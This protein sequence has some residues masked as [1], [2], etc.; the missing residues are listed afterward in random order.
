MIMLCSTL[1][2]TGYA[3][4]ASHHH[5][6]NSL[7]AHMNNADHPSVMLLNEHHGKWQLRVKYRHMAMQ[8]LLD[9][10]RSISINEVFKRGFISS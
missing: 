8:G 4:A 5:Q 10:S 2:L 1:P 9:G 6:Q 7:Q 3:S